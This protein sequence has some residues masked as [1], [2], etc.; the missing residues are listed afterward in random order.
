MRDNTKERIKRCDIR[1]EQLSKDKKKYEEWIKKSGN[2]GNKSSV[3]L[4]VSVI[5]N[6]RFAQ[7][8]ADDALKEESE[9]ESEKKQNQVGFDV[10]IE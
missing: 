2:L 3:S 4:L 8:G 5:E 6:M 9:F 1:Y 7:I 10:N